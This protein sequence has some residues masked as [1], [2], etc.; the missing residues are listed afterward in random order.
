MS[1][2]STFLS[3]TEQIV[4]QAVN[5]NVAVMYLVETIGSHNAGRVYDT[6]CPLY[7][8]PVVSY[9][10][11]IRSVVKAAEKLKTHDPTVHYRDT[12]FSIFWTKYHAV[13]HPG[14]Y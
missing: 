9:R 13:P 3:V 7:D 4:R 2:N 11:S 12:L 5:L 8:V 14:W 1:G 6:V 10:K